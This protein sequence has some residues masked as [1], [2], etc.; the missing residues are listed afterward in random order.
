MKKLLTLLATATLVASPAAVVVACG[1]KGGSENGG[2]NL[3]NANFKLEKNNI[4]I[5]TKNPGSIKISNWEILNTKSKPSK[6]TYDTD[7]IVQATIGLNGEITI[8]P[9]AN[10]KPSTVKVTVESGIGYK[11]VITVTIK[12]IQQEDSFKLDKTSIEME[13][14]KFNYITVT[15]WDSLSE[16]KKPSSLTFN[17]QGYAEAEIDSANHRI[18]ITANN[19]EIENLVLTVKSENGQTVDVNIKITL[20]V[21]DLAQDN[22]VLNVMAGNMTDG[23]IDPNIAIG[24][25]GFQITEESV[26]NGFSEM[27]GVKLNA[28]DLKIEEIDSGNNGIGALYQISASENSK[29]VKGSNLVTLNQ[30]IDPSDYFV[31]RDLGEIRL[32]KGAFNSLQDVLNKKDDSMSL[33]AIIFEQIGAKNKQLEYIKNNLVKNLGAGGKEIM[34]KSTVSATTFKINGMPELGGIFKPNVKVEFTQKIVQEDR[35]TLFEALPSNGKVEIDVHNFDDKT[36]VGQIKAKT[37]VYNQ[38]T[39]EFKNKVSLSHF[40]EFTNIIFNTKDANQKPIDFKFDVLPGSDILYGHDGAAFQGYICAKGMVAI[41]TGSGD[42]SKYEEN[43]KLEEKYSSGMG[44]FTIGGSTS[45]NFYQG[46][47]IIQVKQ[48]VNGIENNLAIENNKETS[49]QF[50]LSDKVAGSNYN[51]TAEAIGNKVTKTEVVENGDGTY[52]LK[53]TP[54]FKGGIIPKTTDT[55][56]IKVNGFT[57]MKLE[58]KQA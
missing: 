22:L 45:G 53:M 56:A 51:V 31:N 17:N 25:D 23:Y 2:E 15:N 32:F 24:D 30:G 43:K 37:E 52:T 36:K 44:Y 40:I 58:I 11:E 21:F 9:L 1:D 12:E 5:D 16:D 39:Q 54:S 48:K 35:I 13:T 29:T 26:I 41:G 10:A 8:S 55:I 46:H 3:P 20:S 7:G 33:A 50:T 38:L 4:E 42:L 19:K 6:F 34:S 47:D 49:L 27:N 18:K 57:T 14:S 28:E